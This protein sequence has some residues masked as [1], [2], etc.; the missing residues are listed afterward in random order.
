MR[1]HRRLNG[2]STRPVPAT[3]STVKITK[4]K[5]GR[6]GTKAVTTIPAINRKSSSITDFDLTISKRGGLLA[7]C[8]DGKLWTR[9]TAAFNTGISSSAKVVRPCTGRGWIRTTRAL[10]APSTTTNR[11]WLSRERSPSAKNFELGARPFADRFDQ[12]HRGPAVEGLG[13][14]DFVVAQGHRV[15]G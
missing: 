13:V 12:R 8:P 10:S 3:V 11:P 4:V 14:Q 2:Y 7:R 9:V 1:P 5:N 15:L 6:Y